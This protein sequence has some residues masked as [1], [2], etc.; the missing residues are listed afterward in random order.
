MLRI[1][2]TFDANPDSLY[3][4]DADP[5]TDLFLTRIRIRLVPLMRIRLLIFFWRE[6]GFDLFLW[7]GSGYWSFF[8]ANPDSLYLFDADPVTD[9]F[10]DAN[11]DLTCPFDADPV[12]DFIFIG[13]HSSYWTRFFSSAGLKKQRNHF[14]AAVKRIACP[15]LNECPSFWIVMYWRYSWLTDMPTEKR[16]IR[17]LPNL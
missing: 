1:R 8:D 15:W 9:F 13:I 4:F 3:L 2:I 6:S 11:P 7:C 5:V 14:V 17:E 16:T 12:T 10:F